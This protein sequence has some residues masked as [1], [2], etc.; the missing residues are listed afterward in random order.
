[1][2]GRLGPLEIQT[3]ALGRGTG[4]G[5]SEVGHLTAWRPQEGPQL[6]W[7]RISVRSLSKGVQGFPN[8]GGRGSSQVELCHIPSPLRPNHHPTFHLFM[9]QIRFTL[10]KKLLSKKERKQN[11]PPFHERTEVPR[12]EGMKGLGVPLKGRLPLHKTRMPN[13]QDFSGPWS[14]SPLP[15]RQ[16]PLAAFLAPNTEVSAHRWRDLGREPEV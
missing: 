7:L 8:V 1:M 12:E 14:L 9:L 3:G 11:T 13:L 2:V 15:M 5:G 16:R 4:S 6:L 10:N